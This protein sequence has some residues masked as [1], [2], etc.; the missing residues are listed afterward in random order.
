MST[1][2]LLL[3][4]VPFLKSWVTLPPLGYSSKTAL[5][6]LSSELPPYLL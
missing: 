1:V 3:E 4:F 5:A 2:V 6:E